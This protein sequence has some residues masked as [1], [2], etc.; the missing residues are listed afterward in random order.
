MKMENTELTERLSYWKAL[1][2]L[3]VATAPV[4]GYLLATSKEAIYPLWAVIF[5]VSLT[6]GGILFALL[7]RWVRQ[8]RQV[9]GNPPQS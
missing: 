8:D 6:A 4:N 2:A 9:V 3:F 7:I 5:F 1:T